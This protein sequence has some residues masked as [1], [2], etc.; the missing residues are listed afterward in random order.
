M[1]SANP[2]LAPAPGVIA[3]RKVSARL[4]FGVVVSLLYL[5]VLTLAV[6]APGLLATQDPLFSDVTRAL[7]PPSLHNPLGTDHLG[8]DV[9]TRIIHGARYSLFI[10]VASTVLGVAVGVVLGLVAGAS[11]RLV[12][13]GISRFFDVIGAFPD[14][15]FALM[16]ITFTGPGTWN[17]IFA[18]GIASA[19][20]YGRIVRAETLRVKESEY[21]A[22]ARLTL[23]SG[24]RNAVKHILPNALGTVPI[25]A[26][27]GVG[28]AILGAAGLSFLGFGPEPPQPE[29][30]SMLS[31][32]RS[33]LR[34]AWWAGFFPGL[35]I[36]LT[37][38]AVSVVG[39]HLQLRFER[40]REA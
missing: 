2:T 19:P 12:N 24:V 40:R 9:L 13:E 26:T 3:T 15:L 11:H 34:V 35:F 27:L 14:L 32:A 36:T 18:I 22:Q 30:G 8:R 7:L 16:L 20:R 37:V 31:E 28:T 4:P 39:R 21:V 23:T 17:L 25:L 1:A 38:I 33:D 6:V 29:W 10:G 5:A